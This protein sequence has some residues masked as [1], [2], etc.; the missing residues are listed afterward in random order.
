MVQDHVTEETFGQQRLWASV[1]W[2][3]AAIIGGHLVDMASQDSL[4]YQYGVAFFIYTVL[5]VA[6]VVVIRKLEVRS[7]PLEILFLRCN[8]DYGV[9]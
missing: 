8:K 5:Y 4:L 7:W 9:P 1:G 3:C 2:G 6:D